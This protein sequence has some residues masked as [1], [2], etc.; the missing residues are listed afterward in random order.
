MSSFFLGNV[1]KKTV[2]L[3]HG[4]NAKIFFIEIQINILISIKNISDIFLIGDVILM[5]L[6]T[7]HQILL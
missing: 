2:L 4:L 7:T 6:N 1:N 3:R 5:L